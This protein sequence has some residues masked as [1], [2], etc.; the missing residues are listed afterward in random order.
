VITGGDLRKHRKQFIMLS[1][2]YPLLWSIAK[3]DSL[4]WFTPGHKLVLSARRIG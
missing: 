4:L 1:A 2:L 3:L